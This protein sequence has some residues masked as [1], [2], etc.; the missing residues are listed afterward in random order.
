MVLLVARATRRGFAAPSGG[1]ELKSPI[2]PECERYTNQYRVTT[3]TDLK[4]V[5]KGFSPDDPT[6]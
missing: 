3:P 1:R 2:P 5:R 4:T 6:F